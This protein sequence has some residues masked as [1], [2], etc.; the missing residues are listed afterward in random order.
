MDRPSR[1]DSHPAVALSSWLLPARRAVV[2]DQ[3]SSLRPHCRQTREIRETVQCRQYIPCQSSSKNYRQ[4]MF[5]IHKCEKRGTDYSKAFFRLS[6]VLFLGMRYKFVF[7]STSK[8]NIVIFLKY[9]IQHCFI[10]RPLRFHCVEGC[11]DR[12]KDCCYFGIGSQTQ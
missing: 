10:C 7:Y 3:L 11:W 4:L 12:T 6:V 1:T 8:V 2:L 9:F 5:L